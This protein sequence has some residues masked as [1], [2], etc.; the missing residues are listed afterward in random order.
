MIVVQLLVINVWVSEDE[1]WKVYFGLL[2]GMVFMSGCVRENDFVMI[3]MYVQMRSIWYL[4]V[5]FG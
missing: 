4:F 2:I 3:M 1:C 5:M